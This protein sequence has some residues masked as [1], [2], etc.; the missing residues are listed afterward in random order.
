M[1][2]IEMMLALPLSCGSSFLPFLRELPFYLLLLMMFI[3]CNDDGQ[4][5]ARAYPWAQLTNVTLSVLKCV[6]PK[7]FIYLK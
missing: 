2:S 1:L 3:C 6:T 4:Y 7:N 5:K